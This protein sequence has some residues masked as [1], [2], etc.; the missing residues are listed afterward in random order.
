VY[1]KYT[2]PV[3]IPQPY[4]PPTTGIVDP[5]SILSSATKFKISRRNAIDVAFISNIL[6]FNGIDQNIDE[7]FGHIYYAVNIGK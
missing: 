7:W 3:A 4:I 6:S 5:Q 1:L 2:G